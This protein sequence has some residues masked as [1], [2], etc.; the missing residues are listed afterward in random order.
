MASNS[1]FNNGG[2]EAGN[3]PISGSPLP[4]PPS[5]MN[6][7]TTSQNGQYQI[8][9]NASPPPSMKNMRKKSKF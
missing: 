4:P 1:L 7:V 3:T 5:R 6:G 8:N 2:E 9:I